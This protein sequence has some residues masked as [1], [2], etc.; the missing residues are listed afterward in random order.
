MLLDGKPVCLDGLV[1]L[2]EESEWR[3]AAPG[4]SS[5]VLLQAA[6]RSYGVPGVAAV[7]LERRKLDLC[8]VELTG[9][10]PRL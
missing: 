3:R 8:A 4:C 6:G 7:Q 5:P 10:L 9:V 2:A 1:Q